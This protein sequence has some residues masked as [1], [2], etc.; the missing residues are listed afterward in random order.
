[1]QAAVLHIKLPYLDQW[2]E[3]R[4][5]IA[6]HYTQALHGL[7]ILTPIE[8]PG[9]RHVYHLYVIQTKQR[10]ALRQYLENRG[11]STGIHYPIPIHLQKVCEDYGYHNG[12]LPITET[13][14]K[15]ILSLPIYPEL[16]EEQVDKIVTEINN[17]FTR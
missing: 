9:N 4:R 12:S 8:A 10:E 13:V 7:E 11:I 6:N 1:L 2:N 15:Q 16:R 3:C 5:Q 17:F 14:T